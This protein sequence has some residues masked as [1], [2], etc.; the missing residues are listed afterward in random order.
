ML[1]VILVCLSLSGCSSAPVIRTVPVEVVRF[2]YL[3]I[4]APLLLDCPSDIGRL[5][6]NGDLLDAYL[7]EKRAKEECQGR[8]KAIREL[9]P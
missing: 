5:E 2:Q 3:P 9:K 8:L 4:P 1:G 7:E 6:T